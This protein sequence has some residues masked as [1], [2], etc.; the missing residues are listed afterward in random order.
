MKA[1]SNVLIPDENKLPLVLY[2]GDCNVCDFFVTFILRFDKKTIFQFAPIQ[3]V[4]AQQY[5]SAAFESEIPDSVILIEKGLIYTKS[6]AG[7]MIIKRL[8]W[9]WKAFYPLIF[10]PKCIRDAVYKY[11]ARNRYRWFG[12][13]DYCRIFSEFDQE[14]FLN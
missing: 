11:I 13:K 6:T 3:G 5:I 12:K 10:V 14:R 4:T 2:D 8:S 9:P 7:L 1:N